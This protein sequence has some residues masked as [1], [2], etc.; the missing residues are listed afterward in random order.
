M[1]LLEIRRLA[2]DLDQFFLE[3]LGG[4]EFQPGL[5]GPRMCHHIIEDHIA[6]NL[7]RMERAFHIEKLQYPP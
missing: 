3:T 6:T 1:K 5:G 4:L 7:G 2:V